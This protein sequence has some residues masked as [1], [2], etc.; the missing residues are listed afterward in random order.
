MNRNTTFLVGFLALLVIVLA[1]G[2]G[3]MYM[4]NHDSGHMGGGAN[5]YMT[6]MSSMGQMDSDAMLE[7]MEAI[8]G[9]E[10]FQRLLDHMA[11]HKT[12]SAPTDSAVSEMMHKMMDG[13]MQAMPSDSHHI[14]PT[15]GQ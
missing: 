2:L 4:G 3:A 13:M 12:G 1:V 11:A 7:Q 9:P 15:E 14:L 10:D 6:M 5:A 8:L